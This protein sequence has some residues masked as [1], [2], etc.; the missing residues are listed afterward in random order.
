MARLETDG[1]TSTPGDQVKQYSWD[2]LRVDLDLSQYIVDGE[3]DAE[4]V[5]KPGTVAGQQ[6]QVKNCKNS[7]VYLFD[8]ANT[9]TI[10]DCTNCKIF[11]GSVKTSV[12]MRDC[13]N[14]VLV[15]TCGQLR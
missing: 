7:N 4:V 10:D 11:L 8:W 5:R 6:F 15:T 12:F 3:Q 1:D 14:C 13:S 9:V 2:K